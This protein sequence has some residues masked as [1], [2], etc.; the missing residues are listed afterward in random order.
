M[1]PQTLL[2]DPQEKHTAAG[3]EEGDRGNMVPWLSL[4]KESIWSEGQREAAPA[5][6][7]EVPLPCLKVILGGVAK[8][9]IPKLTSQFVPCIPPTVPSLYPAPCCAQPGPRFP[10]GSRTFPYR[11]IQAGLGLSHHRMPPAVAVGHTGLGTAVSLARG[12]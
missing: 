12:H 3:T 9:H 10:V 1:L 4:G 6:A 2:W 11:F 7:L 8:D 5:V